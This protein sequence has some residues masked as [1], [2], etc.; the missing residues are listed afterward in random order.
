MSRYPLGRISP[1]GSGGKSVYQR[2]AESAK[3]TSGDSS[4]LT[5][6]LGVV[7]GFLSVA[8]GDPT[9]IGLVVGIVL[10]FAGL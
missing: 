8:L 4:P 9:G 3:R 10:F 7:I 6:G 2:C 1:H 5:C